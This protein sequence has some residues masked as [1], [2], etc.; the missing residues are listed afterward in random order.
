MATRAPTRGSTRRAVAEEGVAALAD[1]TDDVARRPPGPD[2]RLDAHDAVD[3]A[4]ERR[5]HQV[6]HAG[7]EDHELARRAPRRG[8]GVGAS[9]GAG[10]MS[11]IPASSA[12]AL[13]DSQRPGSTISDRPVVRAAAATTAA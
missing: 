9:S 7:V 13:P 5:P 1:G 8:I 10:F 11:M 6:G 3:G 4:V 2:G 12:P